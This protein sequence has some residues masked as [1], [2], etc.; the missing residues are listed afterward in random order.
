MG[1]TQSTNHP[2]ILETEYGKIKGIEQRDLSGNP[3]CHRYLKV[4]YARPPIGHLR[5]RRPQKLPDTFSF[6]EP[7]GSPGD[8]T[9]FGPIC[10]QPYYPT[11]TVHLDNP[12]AAPPIENVQSEDCL[13]LNIWVPCGPPPQGGWPVQFHI[14]GGWLQV[15]NALQA[16]DEDPFDL[17][18]SSTPR[19]IVSS[20]YR[21][22]LFGFLAGADLAECAEDA[23]PSN[24]GLWDQRCALEWTAKNVSS[25]GGNPDNITVGGLSAGA[26]STFFQLYYDSHLP[27]DQ[28]LIKRI[29]LWSNAVAIQPAPITSAN[30]TTQF[31]DLCTAHNISPSLPAKDKLTKLR[32]I[33]S[34]DLIASLSKL[35]RHTFRASTDSSFIPPSFL[36]SLHNGTFTTLLA[37]HNIS[38]LLGEV[39]D[40]YQ[41]YKIVN[42]PSTHS[43]LITQLKNYYPTPVVEALIH[44]SNALY[45]IPQKDSP[46]T[47]QTSEKFADVF[48]KIVADVQV[49]ASTRSLVSLLLNPPASTASAAS[50]ESKD[51][52]VST[53]STEIRALSANNVL[54]YK[55][56]WRSEG[57][58]GWLRREVGMCHGSDTPIWWLSGFRCGYTD[59]DKRKVHTFLEPFGEFL[60]GKTVRWGESD[61]GRCESSRRMGEDGA[62]NVNARVQEE[63][64]LIRYMDSD[65]ITHEDF[66]DE[67]WDRGIKVA[68]VVWEAQQ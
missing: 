6:D 26:N 52:T 63:M 32:T 8:H 14:H 44:P 58:D 46:D 4:P 34:E 7:S 64:K 12:N 33:S 68:E 62:G 2:H 49:H 30:L 15:G 3:I 18:R 45:S 21:L 37:K 60:Y 42:P 25:F 27:A 13:Y 29:Y 55:I 16:H 54:R 50:K 17:L 61:G 38:I 10:P 1:A 43:E 41:L 22:N 51:S 28:R 39:R 11:D 31:N 5:W 20:T 66:V 53:A 59:E 24:Y 35:E 36:S 57:M 47:L 9:T 48:G 40:E 65:G 19:I 23:A 67:E 56:S